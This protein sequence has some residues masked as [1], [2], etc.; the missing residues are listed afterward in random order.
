MV[1]DQ[2]EYMLH[3]DCVAAIV[4]E[5]STALFPAPCRL[6][7]THK[8]ST[9]NSLTNAAVLLYCRR[10]NWNSPD[11]LHLMAC[12]RSDMYAADVASAPE[13][14]YNTSPGSTEVNAYGFPAGFFHYPL[15]GVRRA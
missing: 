11:G 10:S 6:S 13:A 5:S 9:Q 1:G 12:R 15:Q 14:F 3:A 4:Y 8:N 2:V 7:V